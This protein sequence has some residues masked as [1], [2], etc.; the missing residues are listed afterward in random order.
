MKAARLGGGGGHRHDGRRG[1][2]RR[3][4]TSAARDYDERNDS[5]DQPQERRR[6]FGSGSFW[7]P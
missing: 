5:G 4:N 3:G 6:G 7:G 1:S 2:F